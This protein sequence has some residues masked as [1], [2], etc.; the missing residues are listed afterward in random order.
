M[1]TFEVLSLQLRP[2]LLL[3]LHIVLLSLISDVALCCICARG[4]ALMFLTRKKRAVAKRVPFGPGLPDPGVVMFC[5]NVWLFFVF[6]YFLS[7][8]EDCMNIAC[9]DLLTCFENCQ[10]CVNMC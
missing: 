8:F 10:T 1:R 6:K 7:S 4:M 9:C 5:C 2:C 3:H